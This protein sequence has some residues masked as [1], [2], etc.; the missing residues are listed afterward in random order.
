[1]QNLLQAEGFLGS[2][3]ENTTLGQR[4]EG[5]GV[6]KGTGEMEGVR[7]IKERRR[8]RLVAVKMCKVSGQGKWKKRVLGFQRSS[9]GW[10]QHLY[11]GLSLRNWVTLL[12]SHAGRERVVAGAH[13]PGASAKREG[14]GGEYFERMV[15]VE[16]KQNKEVTSG[17][18]LRGPATLWGSKGRKGRK[19]FKT[20]V[21]IIHLQIAA[22][23]NSASRSQCFLFVT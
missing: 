1:M 16:L 6:G 21:I 20:L 17:E 8:L 5:L 14:Q 10:R 2:S 3:W 22:S 23:E 9:Q 12:G 15:D 13:H 7:E 11:Y 4:E 18:E 19:A